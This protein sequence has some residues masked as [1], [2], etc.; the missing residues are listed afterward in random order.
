MSR[1]KK[2]EH[3]NHERWMVSYADFVT[4]LFAFFVVMFASSRQDHQKAQQAGA[5][6]RNA[7]QSMGV[8]PS[9]I[10]RPNLSSVVVPPSHAVPSEGDLEAMAMA[11]E[12]LRN[13]EHRMERALAHQIANGMVTVTLGRAGLLISL[14]DAGFFHSGSAVPIASSL[15]ALN[16]IGQAIATTP[17]D[18]RI[19][20]HTDDVP[21]HNAQYSD[22]WELSTARATVLTRLFIEEDHIAPDRLSA[23]GYAQY[24]P[25][26]S[27][28]TAG[29]RGRNRR[30]DIIVLPTRQQ[31]GMMDR[32]FAKHDPAIASVSAKQNPQQVREFLLRGSHSGPPSATLTPSGAISLAGSGAARALHE[33]R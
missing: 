31:A 9:V 3:V 16:A 28:L 11:M 27:N 23:A 4:L 18:V 25:I 26:A 33:R 19:E 7:F 8:F 10:N 12:D 13:L 1:K 17:Y 30:V 5:S 21:I 14:S 2:H 24:H 15:P 20:G 32:I 22:N 6:I 29:G